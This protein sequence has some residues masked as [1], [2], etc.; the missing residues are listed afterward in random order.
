MDLELFSFERLVPRVEVLFQTEIPSIPFCS[1]PRYRQIFGYFLTLYCL[2]RSIFSL[3]MGDNSSWQDSE[4][5][6][7]L[8]VQE[9]TDWIRP[10]VPLVLGPVTCGGQ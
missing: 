5:V 4:R 3:G 10:K 7:K 6:L 8:L 2:P 1:W 9:P